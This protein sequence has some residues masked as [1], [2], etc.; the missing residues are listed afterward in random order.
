MYGLY[1]TETLGKLVETVQVL[2]SCQS[3]LEQLFAGQQV[4]AYKIYSKMQNAH[5]V[6]HYVMNALLYLCTIKEKYNAVY[7]EFINQVHILLCNIKQ[8][9]DTI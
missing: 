2:H 4:V 7:N 3:L 9:S 1:N 5:S 6:Q 8:Y